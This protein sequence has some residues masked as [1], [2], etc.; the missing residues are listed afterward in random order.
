MGSMVTQARRNAGCAIFGE[1]LVRCNHLLSSLLF[2]VLPF[3]AK[4]SYIFVFVI[5]TLQ[6]LLE[7]PSVPA[8]ASVVSAWGPKRER[9]RLLT[10]TYAGAYL[11]PAVGFF[12]TGVTVCRVSWD[13]VFFIYGGLGVLWFILWTALVYDTPE[14]CPRGCMSER[15]RVLL[16]QERPVVTR[17]NQAVMK[18][19][20]WRKILTSVPVFAVLVG[21]FCRNYVFSM[22][23]TAQPQYFHDAFT[24]DAAEIG[25]MSAIPSILMTV[26]VICG[27]FLFDCIIHRQYV[28]RTCARKLAQSIGFGVEALCLIFLFLVTSWQGAVA[29]FC[30]GVGLS[31]FAISGYQ[32]NPLDLSPQYAGLLTGLGRVG[33]IG[34]I[35]STAVAAAYSQHSALHWRELFLAAGVIHLVGVILYDLMASGNLQPWDPTTSVSFSVGDTSSGK[36][37]SVQLPPPKRRILSCEWTES[38]SVWASTGGTVSCRART[39]AP[40]AVVARP[41]GQLRAALTVAVR[42]R[43]LWSHTF[44]NV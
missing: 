17:G 29:L 38:W 28:S 23:I 27:G 21:A 15:E 44:E 20:P 7:G 26:V 25:L 13:S 37:A 22:L 19:I 12:V 36:E 24:M 4:Q 41:A 6:G 5:R 34:S 8:A 39:T 3:L 43:V 18:A 16:I 42:R 33:T 9:T 35:I 1:T 2:I 31:G 11:S 32:A 40:L 14:A 10:I 30:V